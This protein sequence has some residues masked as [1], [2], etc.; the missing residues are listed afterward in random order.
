MS[1][2]EEDASPGAASE[3]EPLSISTAL[4]DGSGS[5][6]DGVSEKE[7][8]KVRVGLIAVDV[9]TGK[10]VHDTFE[11][12]SGQRQELHTRL[13]HLR[14]VKAVFFFV[15][16]FLSLYDRRVGIGSIFFMCGVFYRSSLRLSL[17]PV[18]ATAVFDLHGHCSSN[19]MGWPIWSF[20]Q[21]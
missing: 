4:K 12:D 13:R 5:G 19:G 14:L 16:I 17:L 11:E 1:I 2:Y 20:R 18:R 10:V 6:A 7:V 9:R 8:E 15:C 21:S 3:G